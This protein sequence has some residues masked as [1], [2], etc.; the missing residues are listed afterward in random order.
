VQVAHRDGTIEFD[1]P[2]E[3]AGKELYA[4][5]IFMRAEGKGKIF[6]ISNSQR[7]GSSER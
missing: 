2:V 5:I 3:A 6:T 7:V 4:F 1:L